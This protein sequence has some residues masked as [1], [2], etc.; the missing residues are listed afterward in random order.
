MARY[1]LIDNYSGYIF[2]DTADINGRALQVDNPIDAARAFDEQVRGE[3]G[4][5]YES[6]GRARLASNERELYT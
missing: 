1:I 6:I 4:R 3:H 2:G 5:A